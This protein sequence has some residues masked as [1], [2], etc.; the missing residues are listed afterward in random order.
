MKRRLLPGTIQLDPDY[1]I[2]DSLFCAYRLAYGHIKSAYPAVYIARLDGS[3]RQQLLPKDDQRRKATVCIS[4]E[5]S[6]VYQHDG[7]LYAHDLATGTVRALQ[8]IPQEPPFEAVELLA[9]SPD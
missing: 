2:A 9:V 4:P 7:Q 3:P 6:A 1:K 5:G 8:G